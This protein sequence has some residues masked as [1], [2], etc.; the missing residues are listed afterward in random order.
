MIRIMRFFQIFRDVVRRSADVVPAMA[1]PFILV[2]SIL[3]V[4]VYFGISL[5]G[6]AVDV[7]VMAQNENITSLYYLNNF[8][9]YTEGLITMFNVLVVNDWH[10]IAKVFLYADRCSSPYLVYPFFIAGICFGVFIMVNVITA[11]FVE[12]KFNLFWNGIISNFMH[13]TIY[14][15]AF[16]T[17]LGDVSGRRDNNEHSSRVGENGNE[18]RRLSASLKDLSEP[19]D[20]EPVLE[21]DN[22][23]SSSS[24]STEI[25]AFDVYE[26]GGFDQIMRTVAGA[27]DQAQEAFA[28]SICSY[29]EVFESLAEGR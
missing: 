18:K 4:F 29:L 15:A 6:G 22:N 20:Q 1:G 3:H 8:N 23:S 28:R 17:K 7:E 26:R 24:K 25:F 12:C 5:W 10:E 21:A 14:P 27:S 16:V 2:L 11:F 19:V 9:S 13:L